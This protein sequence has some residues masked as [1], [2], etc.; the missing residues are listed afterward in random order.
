LIEAAQRARL[1]GISAYVDGMGP[2]MD[3]WVLRAMASSPARF[4]RA[5][6]PTIIRSFYA[7][8]AKRVPCPPERYWGRR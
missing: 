8:L 1:A 6:E 5:P 7:D 4:F 3:E 2:S